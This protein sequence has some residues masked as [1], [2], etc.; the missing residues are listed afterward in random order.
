MRWIKEKSPDAFA[1]GPGLW[2]SSKQRGCE[3]RLFASMNII[4]EFWDVFK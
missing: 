1:G 4:A 3:L 2:D